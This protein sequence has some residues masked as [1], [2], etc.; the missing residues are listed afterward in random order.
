MFRAEELLQAV[1]GCESACEI[2]ALHLNTVIY[3][4]IFSRESPVLKVKI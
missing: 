1:L 2:K 3:R 4:E